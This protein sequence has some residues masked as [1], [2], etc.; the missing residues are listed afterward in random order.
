MGEILN[1]RE[2]IKAA[3]LPPEIAD[4]SELVTKTDYATASKAGVV[5]VGTN[6]NVASGKISVP[7]ASD[8]VAGVVKVGT[9]LEVDAETGALNVTGGGGGV[10]PVALYEGNGSNLAYTF[11]DGKSM[12]DYNFIVVM[13]S[14]DCHG[15]AI[16]PVSKIIDADTAG[17]FVGVIAT[18][19]QYL[20]A[21]L[22]PTAPSRHSG[23]S[24]VNIIG[25]YAF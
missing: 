16:V 8:E 11:P 15:T 12:S 10:T 24:G 9:G 3:S 7:A 5:K 17:E 20:I 13:C 14:G 25:I 23:Q 22:T 21:K 4:A 2:Q 19:T 18:P 1:R 6:I